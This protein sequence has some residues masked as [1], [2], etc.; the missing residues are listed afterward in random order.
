MNKTALVIGLSMGRQYASWLEQLGYKVITADVDPARKAF[1][2]DYADAVR[3]SIYDIIYIGTP[4][5]THELIAR[6]VVD[7]TKILIIEKPGFVNSTAWK[8][9]A[10]DN[11][12]TRILMVK[13]NQYRLELSGFKDLLKVSKRV[14]VVWSRRAGVPASPWFKEKDRAFGGVS[15]DLMPHLL[16]YYTTLTEYKDGVKVYADAVDRH[17][18]GIDDFCEIEIKNG[19]VN[20]TFTASWQNNKEDLHYI[21]FDLGTNKV[22]FELGDYVTAFGGCPAAPYMAMIQAAVDNID[23][24]NFWQSQLEQDCW[25]HKQVENL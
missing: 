18:T 17:D 11:P 25:I 1:Y 23:N 7:K 3:Y 16:S 13:N 14:N 5:W 21:E 6:D 19:N 4:N 8:K 24:N 20:W 12:N 22:R 10:T 9:L 2:T 15:R